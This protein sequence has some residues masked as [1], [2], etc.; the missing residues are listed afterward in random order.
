MAPDCLPTRSRLPCQRRVAAPRSSACI[1]PARQ[2]AR[3]LVARTELVRTFIGAALQQPDNARLRHQTKYSPGLAR[4]G[5]ATRGI[6]FGVL[7]ST[8]SRRGAPTRHLGIE[9][10]ELAV[11]D[12]ARVQKLDLEDE[13]R[14]PRDLPRDPRVAVAARYPARPGFP[15]ASERI[16]RSAPDPRV[17][18]ASSSS[19]ASS[20]LPIRADAY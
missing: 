10:R 4:H 8:H 9:L 11:G 2:P 14:L 12:D 17:A 18:T 20:V 5:N 19:D 3:V 16:G 13:R 7:L 15:R 1:P 6:R